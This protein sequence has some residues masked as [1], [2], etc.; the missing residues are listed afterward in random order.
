MKKYMKD[1]NLKEVL[2]F[3]DD[4]IVFSSSLE[5]HETR[6]THVL[7][8]LREYGLQLSPDKCRFFQTSVRY[9]GNIVSRDDIKA[10]PDKI[11]ALKTLPKPQTFNSI[12]FCLF[13]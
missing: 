7:E 10:D 6:L 13:I 5:E 12:N 4:L 1:I 8:W 11:E 9:L 3:L 2:F